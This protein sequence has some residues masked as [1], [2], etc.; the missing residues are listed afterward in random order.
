M[1][2]IN[3]IRFLIPIISGYVASALCP[4]KNAGSDIKARPPAVAF[5]I[6]WTILYVLIGIAWVKTARDNP[7]Y[8]LAFIVLVISL[9]A[10]IYLWGCADSKRIAL[11]IIFV[12][13]MVTL[14]IIISLSTDGN[15]FGLLLVPLFIWLILAGMLNYTSVNNI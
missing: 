14:L 9:S 8:D 3:I 13:M 1:N 2:P 6:I 11:Y 15:K 4:I 12:S 7:M 5:V 10:W